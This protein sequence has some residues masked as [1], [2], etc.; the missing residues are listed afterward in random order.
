MLVRY[1]GFID[2]DVEFVRYLMTIFNMAI[3]VRTNPELDPEPI[4]SPWTGA[5]N[6]SDEE[7][8]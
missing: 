6:I 5:D 4:T 1:K 8:K 2:S 3:G 7:I